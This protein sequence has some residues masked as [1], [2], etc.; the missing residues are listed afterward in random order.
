M[1]YMPEQCM[2]RPQPQPSDSSTMA[3]ARPQLQGS[4]SA[5]LGDVLPEPVARRGAQALRGS[6][7]H[8][9][10]SRH[11]AQLCEQRLVALPQLGAALACLLLQG[12]LVQRLQIL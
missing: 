4:S 8:C 2:Q 10:C 12:T 3:A 5:S 1:L 11:I 6:A 9:C 7:L